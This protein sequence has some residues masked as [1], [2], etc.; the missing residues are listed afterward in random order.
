[1]WIACHDWIERRP[2]S[3]EAAAELSDLAKHMGVTLACRGGVYGGAEV[4]IA[5]PR[6]R[7]DAVRVVDVPARYTALRAACDVRVPG[8]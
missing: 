6:E 2:M 1:M 3:T 5:H 8:E 4:V 7:A